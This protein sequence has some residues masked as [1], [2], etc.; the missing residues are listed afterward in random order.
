[1]TLASTTPQI[2]YDGDGSTVDFDF[3]FKMWTET[4]STELA[5]I[6]DEG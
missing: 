3:A 6:L 2:T 1:M 4:V 5:V